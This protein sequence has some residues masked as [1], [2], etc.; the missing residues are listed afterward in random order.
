MEGDRLFLIGID[1][2]DISLAEERDMLL[3]NHVRWDLNEYPKYHTYRIWPSMYVGDLPHRNPDL[4]DPLAS[5][6]PDEEAANWRSSYL[7]ALSRIASTTVPHGIRERVGEFLLERQ[8][9]KTEPDA[10]DWPN[11]VFDTQLS[12]VINMP[13]YNPLPVQQDLKS[14]W[15]DRV[16][17]ENAGLEALAKLADEEMKTVNDELKNALDRGYDLTW[18]YV[19]SPDIFGHVDFGH[20]YP[21]RVDT[22]WNEVVE[23]LRE[24]LGPEDEL[25]LIS[26]HGMVE[27]DGVGEHQPPG[28][29]ATTIE[30][31]DLPEKPKGVRSWIEGLI[32]DRT[33]RRE[34][35]L[36]DLGYIE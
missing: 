14:G 30:G 4:P 16:L 22:V 3:S 34:E 19:Y 9:A 5:K 29:L 18:A 6:S 27:E 26:D 33:D 32:G 21:R 10:D 20:S 25:V 12:K 15:K 24:E 23:P 28:W 36:R 35:T 31:V 11:T 2:V 1:G 17:S 8:I 7:R 13:V